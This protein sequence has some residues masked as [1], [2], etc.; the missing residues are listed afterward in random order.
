MS[1]PRSRRGVVAAAAAGLLAGCAQLPTDATG[2][3]ESPDP[4]AEEGESND[5]SDDPDESEPAEP[6][7]P[8]ESGVAVTDTEITD[9]DEGR[10]RTTLTVEVTIE[11]TGRFT[12]GELE[13]RVNA[14]WSGPDQRE[15]ELAGYEYATLRYGS[16]DRFDDG[17]RT[18]SV[19]ILIEGRPD[20]RTTEEWFAIDTAVRRAEPA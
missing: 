12:Y 2:G 9:I 20:P 16:G 8:E 19:E 14:Y 15:R 4:D 7:S 6:E 1:R 18:F 3:D 11:N 10:T 5:S 13:F 17:T